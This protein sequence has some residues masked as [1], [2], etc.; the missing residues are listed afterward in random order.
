[1]LWI[2]DFGKAL[3]EFV[4][5]LWD[6]VQQLLGLSIDFNALSIIIYIYG[7]TAAVAY[8][9]VIYVFT[10]VIV[11]SLFIRRMRK[12]GAVSLVM[13][14]GIGVIIPLWFLAFDQLQE[15]GDTLKRLM[16]EI[17]PPENLDEVMNENL[18]DGSVVTLSLPV[19]PVEQAIIP[20]VLTIQLAVSGLG[21]LFLMVAY[22]ITNV[23]LTCLG[24]LVFAMYGLGDRTRKFFAMI[25]SI[26]IVTG[27]V[28]IPVILLFT[29]IAQL[30]AGALLGEIDNGTWQTLFIF[31]AVIS[32][33]IL[34]PLMVKAAY[35]RVNQMVGRVIAQV[36]NKLRTT[37]ENKN[38]LD[39]HLAGSQRTTI[40]HRFAQMRVSTVNA[41][42]DKLDNWKMAGAASIS[43]KLTNA[44]DRAS[45]IAKPAAK[46]I[47]P[48]AGVASKA[49][50]VIA[51]IPH[52]AAKAISI[53]APILNSLVK[54]IGNK[55]LPRD[56]VRS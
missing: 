52:P 8:E 44:A 5:W 25:I 7:N 3:N 30:L 56:R 43:Q 11:F 13:L 6:Y 4:K 47:S 41:G 40:T 10:A 2:L 22:E 38:R 12:N 33:L 51:A 24:L 15:I 37:T 17:Q 39:A 1:M 34:Q 50:P 18:I 54:S 27:I 26:F 42:I 53:G 29:Q 9:L 32:A 31:V 14:V 48:V 20:V 46:V 36:D 28:G 45:K 21:L 49:S 23:V 35:K 16:L 19:F 55:P